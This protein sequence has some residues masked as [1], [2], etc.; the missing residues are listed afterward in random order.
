MIELDLATGEEKTI[1][2]LVT[3]QTQES[4]S[5]LE[6]IQNY[7]ADVDKDH[8]PRAGAIGI[9]GPVKDNKVEAVNI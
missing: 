8:L 4:K 5:C 9:A 1:K 6:C 2:G 3:F 7:L